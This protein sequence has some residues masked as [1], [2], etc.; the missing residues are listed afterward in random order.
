MM[1]EKPVQ[2]KS[3]TSIKWEDPECDL[4]AAVRQIQ[5]FVDYLLEIEGLRVY[6]K[7]VLGIE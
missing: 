1:S 7:E 5:E 6:R 2:S 4:I 3:G